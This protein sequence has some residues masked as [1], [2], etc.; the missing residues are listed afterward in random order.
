MWNS[1]MMTIYYSA[2]SFCPFNIFGTNINLLNKTPEAGGHSKETPF[3]V[4][5]LRVRH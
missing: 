5:C 1:P 2:F 4:K 3:T